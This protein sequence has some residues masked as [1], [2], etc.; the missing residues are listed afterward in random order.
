[1]RSRVKLEKWVE[2]ALKDGWIKMDRPVATKKN[3]RRRHSHSYIPNDA[4]WLSKDGF[5]VL[6]WFGE[7]AENC[8]LGV[9]APNG[10]RYE[11]YLLGQQ[12][13]YNYDNLVKFSTMCPHCHEFKQLEP[14]G[15]I[16]KM[17]RECID[18]IKKFAAEN[19]IKER[20]YI[21]EAIIE[22]R[23]VH[24]RRATDKVREYRVMAHTDRCYWEPYNGP[25]ERLAT[26]ISIATSSALLSVGY[27]VKQK[28]VHTTWNGSELSEVK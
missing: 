4:F 2:A 24:G 18:K 15:S 5:E 23:Y 16:T 10:N 22:I 19:P 20:E 8:S 27:K 14:R 26:E 7:R 17:C 25:V 9:H 21:G 11:T 3:S 28:T 1:M 6:V 12:D 13:G